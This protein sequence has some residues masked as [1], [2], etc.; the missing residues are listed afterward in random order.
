MTVIV[1]WLVVL[2]SVFGG[3]LLA[4]GHMAALIQ[5]IELLMIG[6]A[7]LGAFF[8]ANTPKAIKA[9]MKG[10]PKIF[11]GSKL[12]KASYMD[13]LALLYELLGKIRKE[14]MM[15][16]EGDIDEPHNSPLFTK[17]PAVAH[18]HHVIEFITDYLR[19]MV[20]GNLNAF[21]IEAL[22]DQEIETHHKEAE[23]AP[24]VIAKMADAL[25]AFGIVAAVMG[26]VHTM[27][28]LHLPPKE[29]GVLIAHALVGTFLGILLSYGFVGP[30]ASALEQKGHDESKIYEVIKV[31]LLASLNGYAPQVC[32][33]F[34]RKVIF[35]ADR[36]TFSELE[37]DVKARKGK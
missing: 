28:S 26:V 25:P 14:G 10:L 7:G 8:V 31:V 4:G 16:I 37:E 15:S 9:T 32:I 3:F 6:G 12:N 33:E 11:K 21:E 5:P 1:G 18:D 24:M 27:E 35:S 36:P 19:I 13:L 29:L 30:M 34:G 23:V 22:M 2:G 17:Y 20:G